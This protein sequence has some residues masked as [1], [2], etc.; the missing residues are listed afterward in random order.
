MSGPVSVITGAGSGIG[1]AIA[2]LL[3][4]SRHAVVLVGRREETLRE[5]AGMLHPGHGEHAIIAAD[6]GVPA[7]ALGVV[8]QTL[9][10]FKRL[11]NLINNAGTAP[12]M[13][14][15][16]HT[17]EVLDEIYRVNALGPANLIARAWPAFESQGRGC[18]V[19]ISTI[20]TFDPFPGFFG[21]AAAKAALNT[22]TISCAREGKEF[23]IRA[24]AIAPGAVE[25]RMLHGVFRAAGIKP[26]PGLPPERVA[27]VVL[28]CIDGRRDDQNGRTIPL[29]E[30]AAG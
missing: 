23:G 4:A 2:V 15:E 1:R 3:S 5:T 8:D 6:V 18:I 24:F 14:I 30:N 17:P 26:Y 20:G 9:A 27:E 16:R 7:Q 11:D 13:P 21:Y 19:N 25:T 28:E 29:K 12:L 10:R 22:M